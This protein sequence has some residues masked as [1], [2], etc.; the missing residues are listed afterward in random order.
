MIWLAVG[1]V[2]LIITGIFWILI[3]GASDADRRAG[4]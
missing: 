4:R 1:V 2:W 3:E